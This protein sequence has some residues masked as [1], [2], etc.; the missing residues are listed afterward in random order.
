[1]DLDQYTNHLLF[2]PLRDETAKTRLVD[3]QIELRSPRSTFCGFAQLLAHFMS[4]IDTRSA[5]LIHFLGQLTFICDQLDR[6]YEQTRLIDERDAEQT[7]LEGLSIYWNSRETFQFIHNLPVVMLS[8]EAELAPL[9]PGHDFWLDSLATQANL[10]WAAFDMLANPQDP[11]IPKHLLEFDRILRELQ[12]QQRYQDQQSWE[13]FLRASTHEMAY[14]RK[15]AAGALRHFRSEESFKVLLRLLEDDHDEVAAEAS[16]SLR[17]LKDHRAV[18]ALA[19]RLKKGFKNPSYL[20]WIGSALEAM[21]ESQALEA[22]IDT[23][24]RVMSQHREAAWDQVS[25]Y[26]PVGGL[27]S[28]IQAIG[29]RRAEEALK[30]YL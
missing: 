28:A 18:P 19:E 7:A 26:H 2:R 6:L 9:L 11:E 3:L 21:P 13:Q 15:I 24:D 17:E 10:V 20:G 12:L 4:P 22:L 30:R 29:G 14:F 25:K 1:M 5:S 23:L 27:Y 16:D 8:L